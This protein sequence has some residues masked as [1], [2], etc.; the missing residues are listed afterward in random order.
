VTASVPGNT[1]TATAAQ[2]A[3]LAWAA[4]HGRDLPWRRTRDPWAVLVSEVMLA[5]TQVARVIPRWE[6]FVQR[7]PDPASCAAAPVGEVIAAWNG[8]GYNRRALLLHGAA[9]V[10]VE[11]HGGKI[12]ADLDELVAL[13]GVGPYT[14]RAV[15]AF[16]FDA[17]VGVVD[18]NA[19][20]VLARAIAGR[21]L[22]RSQAQTLADRSVPPGRGWEW[23]QALLD[24]GALRCTNRRPSCPKCP[25]GPSSAAQCAWARRRGPDP[26]A[27][28]AGTSKPQSRFAGSD[29][30]G[31]GRIIAAMSASP[32]LGID[33][34]QVAA[35]AGWPDDPA[36]A[37]GVVRGLIADGL[38][39][40]APDG[41]LRL[42]L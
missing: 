10:I 33:P 41:E 39:V 34:H 37:A 4:D 40:V 30:Q 26:A 19:A 22:T 15:M 13:P 24:L 20:R 5:Q 8:L 12:P 42:P 36:R 28:S 35:L 25:L 11:R 21:R 9:S 18:T 14:A 23:N 17:T 7:W 27:G 29:R 1:E 31:R 32:A 3:I 16:A 38:V 2:R 6:A